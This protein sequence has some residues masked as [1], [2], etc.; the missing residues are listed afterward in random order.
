MTLRTKIIIGLVAFTLFCTVPV[1]IAFDM[2]K[3]KFRSDAYARLQDGAIALNNLIDRNLFERYGDVQAFG[4]NRAAYNPANWRNPSESNPLVSAINSYIANY[5]IYKLSMLVGTD[6][7]LLAVNTRDAK[8]KEIDTAPLYNQSFSEAVWFVDALQGKFLEGRNGLTGTVVSGPHA[9]K[10]VQGLYGDKNDYSIN[11]SAPVKNDAGQTIGVWVN[12]AT[13]TLVDDIIKT[14]ANEFAGEKLT[15]TQVTLLDN[16]G[17]VITDYKV[18]DTSGTIDH[19][20]LAQTNLYNDGV[21]AA[22]TAMDSKSFGAIAAINS[23]T[24]REQINGYDYSDGA[25]DYAGLGWTA[26]LRVEPHEIL[27]SSASAEKAMMIVIGII[28]AISLLLSFYVGGAF[29]RPIKKMTETMRHLSEGDTS[30]EVPSTEN[31]DEIGDMAKAVLVFKDNMIQTEQL[32]AEQEKQKAR[33]EA[34]K[35]QAMNAMADGFESSVKSVVT[36]VSSSADQMRSSAERLSVLAG[37]TKSSSAVVSSSAVDAAQTATQVAAAAE[38]LTAAIGEISAQVQKSST[39]ATQATTQAESINQSMYLLVDKSNRVG[40]VIQFITSIASQ[41]N[42]LA[43]NATIESARAGE[44]GRG[45]AVVASEVKTLANQTAKATE[46]I[47]QQVQSMQEATQDA[48]R[49][50]SEIIQIISEI[51]Q[52]TAGVAAAVEEQSAATNE[53]SRNITRTATGTSEISQSIITVEKG[54][55]E[56]GVS[57]RQVLDSAKLLSDQA[58]T[59]SKKVDEFLSQVR[60]S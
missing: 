56:T 29:A 37:E 23:R 33:A 36:E 7:K 17:T 46:E 60:N 40:E 25:Y 32:R 54:A 34:E 49:S 53:I 26:L 59:L 28:M 2:Q 14:Y 44:A 10:I 52:S 43:L 13:F 1:F 18:T 55:D 48:V 58:A 51:S 19:E 20:K 45:F 24:H 38:E 35:R 11:F 9:E 27:A 31:K 41:I 12:F 42:L 5:G 47:V 57:S 50:V 15:T 39:I 6:G 3:S 8:G 30:V 16:K 4:Q 21:K 22:V